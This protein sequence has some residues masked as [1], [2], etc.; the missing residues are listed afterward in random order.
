VKEDLS[1]PTIG[2]FALL[3]SLFTSPIPADP[4]LETEPNNSCATAQNLTGAQ[5]PVSLVGNLSNANGD[6]GVDFYR[7]QLNPWQYLRVDMQGAGSGNGTL[8]D[9]YLGLFDG[10]CQRLEENDDHA[11]LD[12]RLR[13]KAPQDGIIVL[14]AASCCNSDFRGQDESTGTYLLTLSAPPPVLEGITGRIIDAVHWTPI[15]G[16]R[17]T[18]VDVSLV[19]SNGHWIANAQVDPNGRFTFTKDDEGQW[20][21][22]GTYRVVVYADGYSEGR[23]EPF[24]APPGG[25]WDMG[26]VRLVPPPVS[27]TNL[28]VCESLPPEGGRCRISMRL[29]SNRY[30]DQRVEP[31][32]IVQ[33]GTNSPAGDTTYEL[34]PKSRQIVK[35]PALNSRAVRFVLTIPGPSLRDIWLS[36]GGWVAKAGTSRLITLRH[37]YLVE[38]HSDGEKYVVDSQHD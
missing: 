33:G 17:H 13:F 11:G 12:S 37:D 18:W 23:S 5:V 8:Q 7:L 30:Q 22:P 20:L 24:E 3:T 19:T 29:L 15:A 1:Y 10:S 32:L 35:L 14:A 21:E 31:W 34:R 16:G 26:D 27:F 2:V 38:I 28:E 9:P 36:V 6:I 4:L 25:I